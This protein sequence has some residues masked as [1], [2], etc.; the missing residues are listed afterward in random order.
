MSEHVVGEPLR[1]PV[2]VDDNLTTLVDR[3]APVIDG[4]AVVA[5]YVPVARSVGAHLATVVELEPLTAASCST[6]DPDGLA[7]EL[8]A[9]LH[10]LGAAS[11]RFHFFPDRSCRPGAAFAALVSERTTPVPASHSRSLLSK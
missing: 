8:A 11:A 10:A 5:D 4:L 2:V 7:L 9:K 3:L 1:A 6:D